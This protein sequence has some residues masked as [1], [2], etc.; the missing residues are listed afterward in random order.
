MKIWRIDVACWTA[1][2]GLGG[3]LMVT[4]FL[5]KDN[6]GQLV[7]F[8]FISYTLWILAFLLSNLSLIE[9]FVEYLPNWAVRLLAWMGMPKAI[10]QQ[11]EVLKEALRR[12][13]RR[14]TNRII[15]TLNA[16]VNRSKEGLEHSNWR[17]RKEAVE[18]LGLVVVESFG[19]VWELKNKIISL[20]VEMLK[21]PI[22]DVRSSARLVLTKIGSEAMSALRDALRVGDPE[23]SEEVDWCLQQMKRMANDRLNSEDWRNRLRAV[24]DLGLMIRP[25]QKDDINNLGS[26]LNDSHKEV[27]LAVV[28]ALISIGSS[29]VIPFLKQALDDQEDE[30]REEAMEGLDD[31][32]T[33]LLAKLEDE[34][35]M[36]RANAV[37]TLGLIGREEDIEQLKLSLLE[38]SMLVRVEA[39]KA[40]R[41]I[42]GEKVIDVFIKALSD[43]SESVSKEAVEALSEIGELAVEPLGEKLLTGTKSERYLAAETLGMMEISQA[44]GPLREAEEKEADEEVRQVIISALTRLENAI[45]SLITKQNM[46]PPLSERLKNYFQLQDSIK[47]E[48][49]EITFVDVDVVGSTTLKAGEPKEAVVYSFG[50]YNQILTNLIQKHCGEDFNHIGDERILMF[51]NPADAVKMGIEL[52]N[53]LVGFNKDKTRN[54]LS[55]P[56]KIRIGINTGDCLIDS[57]LKSSNVAEHTLDIACHLQKYGE[58]DTVYISETTYSNL[59]LKTQ[60]Q[61]EGPLEF[62]NDNIKIYIYRP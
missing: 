14:R 35:V 59:E 15:K 39:V 50:Q 54:R 16:V 37:K 19:L 49:R 10:A 4:G 25:T 53:T 27:R 58:P 6:I 40:V 43:K 32:R 33:K 26:A 62:P 36:V 38:E 22:A 3:V 60:N 44:A 17:V 55:R 42:G 9:G 21:D 28:K 24:N 12:K 1:L 41:A 18:I 2:L 8:I 46:E 52:Q 30:I 56:F 48:Y 7:L 47:S 61:F 34:D 51:K 23:L 13:N 29:N 45:P 5:Y 11:L 57:M 20:L 31:M